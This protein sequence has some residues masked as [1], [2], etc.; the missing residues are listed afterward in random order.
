MD[1]KII[2]YCSPKGLEFEFVGLE[3]WA[4]FEILVEILEKHLECMV[5]EK[6]D[7]PYSRFCKF[8][9]DG[10]E[11]RLMQHPELGNALLAM[12]QNNNNNQSIRKWAN[13]VLNAYNTVA[14]YIYSRKLS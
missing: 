7:G 9:K 6:Y 1:Y 10:V 14:P 2:E 13:D 5:I 3:D 8:E 12:I 11:F 4:D